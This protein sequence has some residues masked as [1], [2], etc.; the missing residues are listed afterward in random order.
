[1]SLC[2]PF[3]A[4]QQAKKGGENSLKQSSLREMNNP[5]FNLQKVSPHP[6]TISKTPHRSPKIRYVKENVKKK[7]IE[8]ES[9]SSLESQSSSKPESKPE[10]KSELA[11]AWE[12]ESSYEA[13]LQAESARVGILSQL[14]S[15]FPSSQ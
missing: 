3:I 13:D 15:Y 4:T 2:V 9:K 12:S 10:S 1:M 11:L 7:V 6:R 14:E 8:S 5:L